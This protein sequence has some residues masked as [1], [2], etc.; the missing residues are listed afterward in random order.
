[1]FA[2]GPLVALALAAPLTAAE[3]APILPGEAASAPAA[4]AAGRDADALHVLEGVKGAE[5]RLLRAR[6]LFHLERSA[7]ALAALDGLEEP[8]A[9]IV[10]RVHFLRAKVLAALGRDADAAAQWERIGA[11]SILAEAAA[12]ERGRALA[13]AGDEAAALAALEPIAARAAPAD[14]SQQDHA[15][16]ALAARGALLERR[17]PAA[18][19]Q[20]WL[21]CWVDHAVAPEA[22]G[23][24]AALRRLPGEAGRPPSDEQEVQRAER[25][26]EANRNRSAIAALER[27]VAR[28]GAAGASAP[29]ACRARAALGRGYRKERQHSRAMELLRPV[30][31]SCADPAL[32]LRALFVL[33]GSTAISG[34]REEA[35]SLYRRVAKE[36]PAS[37]LADDALVSAADLL[38]RLGRQDEALAV[39]ASAAAVGPDAD[40]RPEALFRGAWAARRAGD[41]AKAE[42]GFRAIEE[43]FRDKDP[44]EHARAAYWRARV[45]A[46]GGE[47][48]R[49]AAT[50]IWEELVRRYPVDWYGLLSR[51][52]LAQT[53][54]GAVDALP[55]PLAGERKGAPTFE[56][57]PLRQDARFR[58]G[59][60][61]LRM[62]LGEEAAEELRA[63]D[64]VALRGAAAGPAP[65]FLVAAL[66]DLAGDHRSAHGILK[67]EAKTL[68]RAPPQGEALDLWRIA[69]PPAFRAEVVRWSTPSRV[70]ADLLQALMREESALDPEVISPAGAIGLTQLMPTTAAAVA[71]RL[72]M[73]AIS[74]S[75][76]TDPVT[77]IRIGAAYLGELLSRYGRQ[78][79]LALAAYN[80]GSG[81]VG[82]W[83]EARGAL[84]LDE[85]V[86][87]IPIDE[88]RGYVK[89]VL[90]TFAAY[91]LLSGVA[92]QEPLDL[93][94][95]ALRNGAHSEAI[96]PAGSGAQPRFGLSRRSD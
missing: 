3:L 44:Y 31:A 15:A 52:R 34:D 23:C 85:F 58:A 90:R 59:L 30:V 92:A 40:K 46:E 50:G 83:L 12:V 72:G 10:D 22:E 4:L 13:A 82:R 68:L 81:A 43:E 91:R 32:K 7:E 51:A 71:R 27:V 19:R 94:P 70:P 54:G 75:S 60:R 79:A 95:R 57:G 35:L 26:L 53:R 86:E 29:L 33:A 2:A 14:L 42:S 84:E 41:R 17:D 80:A 73:G 67:S 36:N 11:G 77:N 66:L 38:E 96:S 56:P 65:V 87:E 24:L 74:A 6:A 16:T 20:A 1:M 89:R 21:A 39:F 25:L 62:G 37:P 47:E 48:G 45:L 8:L 61:L 18:A 78:P 28:V 76:L 9:E 5:A 55:R 49:A 63:I 93:L 88:T 64:L 69:Y